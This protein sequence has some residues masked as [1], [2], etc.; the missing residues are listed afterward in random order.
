MLDTE[1][2]TNEALVPRALAGDRAALAML[3]SRLQTPLYRLA[4]RTLGRR[5]DAED[6]TQ[7][8][9]VTVVTHL[10]E[11]RA[12]SRLLTWAYTIAT[13]ALLKRKGREREEPVDVEQLSRIIDGG[14]ALT[15][16][17]DQPA[18]DARALSREVRLTCTQN[19]LAA[20]SL[21]ERLA[22]LLVELLGADDALGAQLCEVSP[23]A[24][25]Q[26]LSRGRAKLRPVL[27]ERC[28]LSNPQAPCDCT[29]QACAKQKA[30]R[31]GKR[32]WEEPAPEVLERAIAQMGALCK[33]GGVF[34]G[35]GLPAAPQTLFT[36]LQ[37]QFP[38]L[39]G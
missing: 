26:R 36:A 37:D 29:R 1:S 11:F 31:E 15:V 2:P 14:L 25:R 10:A 12:E 24:F 34:A 9:L 23:E 32:R 16:S 7:D 20:L 5:E 3:V 28:G 35:G 19:M 38:D 13:R 33:V 18:G 6:A 30:G 22:V 27:E 8:I 21:E 17:G 4:L 39:L